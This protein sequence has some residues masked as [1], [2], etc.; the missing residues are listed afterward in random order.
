M[1]ILWDLH[2]VMD[3]EIHAGTVDIAKKGK[4]N[5]KQTNKVG[6]MIGMESTK[7]VNGYTFH[8]SSMY[9]PLVVY[10]LLNGDTHQLF[11]LLY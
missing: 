2:D 3:M 1:D 10:Y 4:E 8:W 6:K 9:T 7:V 11:I 5:S